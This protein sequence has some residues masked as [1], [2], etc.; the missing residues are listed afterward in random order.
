MPIRNLNDPHRIT[1]ANR[2]KTKRRI[3]KYLTLRAILATW[4]KMPLDSQCRESAYIKE[5]RTRM[6]QNR[7]YILH[8]ADPQADRFMPRPDAM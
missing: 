4:E 2:I 5:L 6:H 7:N 1:D 8:R 3:D